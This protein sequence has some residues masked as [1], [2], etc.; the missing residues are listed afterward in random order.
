MADAVNWT[1]GP[2]APKD[3]SQMSWRENF[4]AWWKFWG[5]GLGA[6]RDMKQ[7]D[8]IHPTR[9]KTLDEWM[10]KVG[11]QGKAKDVLKGF[12]DFRAKS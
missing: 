7:L 2:G 1:L 11:Y 10:R 9:I 4:T 3:D 6:T 8:E 5:A 12:E